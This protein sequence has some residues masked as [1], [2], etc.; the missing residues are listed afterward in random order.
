MMI[1]KFSFE[2]MMSNRP[3]K[4]YTK[5]NML[6]ISNLPEGCTADQLWQ[7][8]TVLCGSAFLAVKF[9]NSESCIAVFVNQAHARLAQKALEFIIFK[10]HILSAKGFEMQMQMDSI[11]PSFFQIGQPGKSQKYE[12]ANAIMIS[13]SARITPQQLVEISKMRKSRKVLAIPDKYGSDDESY[14]AIE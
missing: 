3:V 12:L 4:E 10:N 8:F 1:V 7:L 6:L 11:I 14:E 9:N 5:T 2:K 13:K